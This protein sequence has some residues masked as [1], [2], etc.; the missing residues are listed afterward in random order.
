MKATKFHHW[1]AKDPTSIGVICNLE[2]NYEDGSLSRVS[3]HVPEH[4]MK[5]DERRHLTIAWKRLRTWRHKELLYAES[6]ASDD[7]DKRIYWPIPI[8]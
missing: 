5:D 1:I 2:W 4:R 3:Q 8:N 7:L 6:M